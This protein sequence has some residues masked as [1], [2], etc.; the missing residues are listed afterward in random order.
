M[1]SRLRP[2]TFVILIKLK[3]YT[4]NQSLPRTQ[5]K[6]T[7]SNNDSIVKQ[8]ENN[9]TVTLCT[10]CIC[11]SNI[12]IWRDVPR[13]NKKDILSAK[14]WT[15]TIPMLEHI[16]LPGCLSWRLLWLTNNT[17][18]RNLLLWWDKPQAVR[19]LWVTD[20]YL[21]R[22][23]CLGQ[24]HVQHTYFSFLWFLLLLENSR[25]HGSSR[26][27]PSLV[28]SET[29]RWDY[30]RHRVFLNRTWRNVQMGKNTFRHGCL[31]Y[32]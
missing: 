15:Q 2:T 13:Y 26:H 7:Y 25:W 21:I 19:L 8:K 10:N 30:V 22:S 32:T 6:Y 5:N 12:F 17:K 29:M 9:T 1:K 4:T 11:K 24:K 31:K 18:R 14:G 28:F 27:P 20:H 16:L 3:Q 23:I